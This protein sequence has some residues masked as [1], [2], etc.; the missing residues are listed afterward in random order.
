MAEITHLVTIPFL[1]IKR[2][3]ILLLDQQAQLKDN[4]SFL[5]NQDG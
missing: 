5:Q 3:L 4:P 2:S 1:F